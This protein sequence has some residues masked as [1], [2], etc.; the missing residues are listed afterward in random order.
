MDSK[1]SRVEKESQFGAMRT[2]GP[3]FKCRACSVSWWVP[4]RKVRKRWM[5]VSRDSR[6]PG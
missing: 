5:F 2:T 1:A 6:G 4:R 3:Y